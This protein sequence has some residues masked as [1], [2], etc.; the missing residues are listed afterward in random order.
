[1]KSQDISEEAKDLEL[2]EIKEG[3]EYDIHLG[4]K[5]Y[6]A[7][8][9]FIA[10]HFHPDDID[11]IINAVEEINTVFYVFKNSENLD[12]YLKSVLAMTKKADA[13]MSFL[14]KISF[15]ISLDLQ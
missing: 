8:I 2:E 3:E 14:V 1:M 9:Q 12:E 6:E 15:V 11:D 10:Y 7:E 4:T 13:E 5:Y